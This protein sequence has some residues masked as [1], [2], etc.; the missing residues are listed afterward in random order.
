MMLMKYESAM[1]TDITNI[2]ES[3]EPKEEE[4]NIECKNNL[5]KLLRDKLEQVYSLRPIKPKVVESYQIGRHKGDIVVDDDILI[6]IDCITD[7]SNFYQVAGKFRFFIDNWK[8]NIFFVVCNDVSPDLL[9]EMKKYAEDAD[10]KRPNKFVRVLKPKIKKEVNTGK[11]NVGK[12]L[13][14][15]HKRSLSILLILIISIYGIWSSTNNPDWQ[16]NILIYVIVIFFSQLVIWFLT[17]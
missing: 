2:I 14:K 8:E 9:K 6:L 17:K 15:R 4:P 7:V 5:S 3:Y 12:S 10:D 16:N 13:I 1:I 11:I